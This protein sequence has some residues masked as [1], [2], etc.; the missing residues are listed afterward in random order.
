[1]PTPAR[2]RLSAFLALVTAAAWLGQARADG[3]PAADP[4]RGKELFERVWR[5]GDPRSRGGDGLGP[6]FNAQSCVACRG[7]WT[8]ISRW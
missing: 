4:A 8:G 5:P 6:V 7:G 2:P 1:M 3:P